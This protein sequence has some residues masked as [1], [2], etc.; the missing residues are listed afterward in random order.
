MGVLLICSINK[1]LLDTTFASAKQTPFPLSQ[2]WTESRWRM[3]PNQWEPKSGQESSE[4]N[5][6]ALWSLTWSNKNL[7]FGFLHRQ[8]NPP[9][10]INIS[11]YLLRLNSCSSCMKNNCF[12][13]GC[14][15]DLHEIFNQISHIAGASEIIWF[16]LKKEQDSSCFN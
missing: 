15:G 16:L 3:M 4:L 12:S 10:I 11:V 9:C 14:V 2:T 1:H 7:C 5:H 8:R 13:T 6:G